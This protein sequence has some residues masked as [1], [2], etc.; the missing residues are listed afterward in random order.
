[1][2][3][4]DPPQR[5]GA[6][7]VD[8]PT[9]EVLPLRSVDIATPPLQVAPVRQQTIGGSIALPRPFVLPRRYKPSQPAYE[10]G[11]LGGDEYPGSDMATPEMELPAGA[12]GYS[13]VPP[14][15]DSTASDGDNAF[16]PDITIDLIIDMDTQVILPTVVVLALITD[17]SGAPSLSD[18][19]GWAWTQRANVSVGTAFAYVYTAPTGSTP[20]DNTV[21]VSVVGSTLMAGDVEAL[22][23]V[24][25]TPV[26]VVTASGAGPTLA[27]TLAALAHDQNLVFTFVIVRS[28]TTFATAPTLSGWAVGGFQSA[29]PN[30]TLGVKAGWNYDHVVADGGTGLI[31]VEGAAA[32]TPTWSE[33][34]ASNLFAVSMEFAALTPAE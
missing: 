6:G 34:E 19:A 25:P 20:V 3:R 32:Q 21:S 2:P 29:G 13:V 17:G 9:I 4:V 27:A 10:I 12:T 30:P 22:S 1:M 15:R 18:T 11:T 28:A 16:G 5:A 8:L 33:A 31:L 26:Q 24:E 23:R 14:F 7:R